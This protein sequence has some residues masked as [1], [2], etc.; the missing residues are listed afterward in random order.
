[1]PE[2]EVIEEEALPIYTEDQQREATVHETEE[3]TSPEK[4][5]DE[6]EEEKPWY[7]ATRFEIVDQ[8]HERLLE[9]ERRGELTAVQLASVRAQAPYKTTSMKEL[10]D[11]YEGPAK[12]LNQRNAPLEIPVDV[13][14]KL[15][16]AMD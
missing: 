3:N 6:P 1:M 8:V 15:F 7:G 10:G 13:V 12:Y 2:G 9:K 11:S 4:T 14:K 5:L 16:I